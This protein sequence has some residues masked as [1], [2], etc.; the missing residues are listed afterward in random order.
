[1]AGLVVLHT[2]LVTN[3]RDLLRAAVAQPPDFCYVKNTR[4]QSRRTRRSTLPRQADATPRGWLCQTVASKQF[5]FHGRR[6]KRW[7]ARAP[8][9]AQ[10]SIRLAA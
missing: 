10:A 8:A 2:Q 9:R 7:N 6:E 4:G 3:E 1:M 5:R